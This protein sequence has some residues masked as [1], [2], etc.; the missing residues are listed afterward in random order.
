MPRYRPVPA[1]GATGQT[2][3]GGAPYEH[4]SD[5]HTRDLTYLQ[6]LPME[7]GGTVTIMGPCAPAELLLDGRRRLQP[8]PHVIG[9]VHVH[10]DAT[11][12]PQGVPGSMSPTI[13]GIDRHPNISV[14]S[15]YSWKQEVRV[16]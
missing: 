15:R 6:A 16:S 2:C 12:F 1:S 10:G 13:R 9:T 4:P 7:L 8:A 11:S 3:L 14:K 5:R